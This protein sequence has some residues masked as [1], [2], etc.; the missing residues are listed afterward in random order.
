MKHKSRDVTATTN[1]RHMPPTHYINT[2]GSVRE[3]SGTPARA[4]PVTPPKPVSG[5][6]ESGIRSRQSTSSAFKLPERVT[7]AQIKDQSFKFGGG[8]SAGNRPLADNV[9]RKVNQP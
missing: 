5:F 1:P 8:R 2:P 6:D 7:P 9:S 4:R 3:R